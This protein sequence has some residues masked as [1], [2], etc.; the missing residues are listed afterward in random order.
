VTP[1]EWSAIKGILSEA[2][3]LPEAERSSYL[4]RACGGDLE[5]RHR[6]VSLIEADQRTWSLVEQPAVAASSLAA[7]TRP[8]PSGERIGAYEI[9]EEIGHGGMGVVYLARRADEQF[10]KRV[11]I[12]LSRVG[13]QAI[14]RHP[15]PDGAPDRREPR[16]SEHREAS[17]RRRD[18]RWAAIPRHG[19]RGGRTAARVLRNRGLATRERLEIFLEVC[20]AVQYAHQHLIVHRDLKPA[21][22]LVTGE[23]RSN[24]STSASLS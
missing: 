2:L 8:M 4:D 5:L 22:I 12:K 3:E 10:E 18:A 15:L 24:C 21:N 6:I 1:E 11:A 23:E 7:E 19:V 14:V 20:A 13:S 9:L 16:S 17:R